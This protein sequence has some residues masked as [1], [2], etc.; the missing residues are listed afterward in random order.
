MLEDAKTILC[1][2]LKS[3][4]KLRKM[5]LEALGVAI[6]LDESCASTRIS[7]YENG[8]HAIEPNTAERLAQVLNVPLSYFYAPDDELAEL[9]QI[10]YE[11]NPEDQEKLLLFARTLKQTHPQ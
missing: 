3:T 7:R 5:T 2:R 11:L 4:R 6:G 8:I 1:R 10:F 9:N